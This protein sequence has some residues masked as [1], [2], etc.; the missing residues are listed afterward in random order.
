ML[1]MIIYNIHGMNYSQSLLVV[2]PGLPLIRIN[3]NTKGASTLDFLKRRDYIQSQCYDAN[4][5]ELARRELGR[6]ER[7]NRGERNEANRRLRRWWSCFKPT[8]T[9]ATKV[10]RRERLET[11]FQIQV[12]THLKSL[13]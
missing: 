8:R 2:F 7:G 3:I 6:R 5:S 12:W 9:G 1:C 11:I 10:K 13:L 4:A